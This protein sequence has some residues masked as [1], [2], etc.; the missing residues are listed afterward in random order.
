MVLVVNENEKNEVQVYRKK[1]IVTDHAFMTWTDDKEKITD[2]IFNEIN[3]CILVIL[4]TYTKVINLHYPY[5]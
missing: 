4:E 3:D 5:L 2:I 1:S